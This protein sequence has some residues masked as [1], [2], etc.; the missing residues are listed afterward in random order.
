M[1]IGIGTPRSGSTALWQWMSR[2]SF[3]RPSTAKENYGQRAFADMYRSWAAND[4]VYFEFTPSLIFRPARLLQGRIDALPAGSDLRL[5]LLLHDPV[6]RAVSWHRL[7]KAKGSSATDA[8]EKIVADAQCFR[9]EA[10]AAIEPKPSWG[11]ALKHWSAGSLADQCSAM[12]ALGLFNGDN[13]KG[14]LSP[15]AS[16]Y[17][18]RGLLSDWMRKWLCAG[19]SP[20]QLLVFSTSE[21]LANNTLVAQ[22]I[23]AEFGRTLTDDDLQVLSQP[24]DLGRKPLTDDGYPEQLAARAYDFFAPAVK[25]LRDLLDAVNITYDRR[26]FDKEFVNYIKHE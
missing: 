1:L 15:F 11:V 2:L 4:G 8:L 13:H 24:V 18:M 25:D 3:V 10:A 20:R 5:L 14:C 17:V 9:N 23:A 19:V 7:F 12:A 6:K 26:M 22:R 16:P 21:L